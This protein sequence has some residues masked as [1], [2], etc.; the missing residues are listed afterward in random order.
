MPAGRPKAPRTLHPSA[1]WGL[2]ILVGIVAGFGAVGFRDLIGIFHNL[3]FLGKL[4]VYYDANAH[5]PR[6]PWGP[7]VILI[8]VVG[9]F[10]VVFLVKNFAPEAK[11]HGVPEV[12]D[13]VYNHKGVIRPIVSLVKALASALSIGSGASIGREGPII[14]IGSSFGSTIGQLLNLAVWQRITLIAAGAGGGIA[15][16]FNTPVGGLLF[17]VE[18]VMHEIS[19]RTLVPVVTAT[20]T[21]TYVGRVFFGDHPSFSVPRLETLYFR[22]ANPEV[23]LA[24]ILL[25][26]IT[27]LAAA[28]FIYSVYGM[29]TFFDE[30]LK[31]SYYVKHASAMLIVGLLMYGFFAGA[32]HYYVEGVGYSTIQDILTGTAFPIYFL[33]LLFAGKLL[34]TSL[35]LGSGGS[36]G[37]FSPSLFLGATIGAAYGALLHRFFPSLGVSVPAFAVVAMAGVVGG[38][39]GAAMASIVM[40]FEMTLDYT[41]ILPL[42]LTV[43]VSYAV[44]RRLVSD[45]IYTRKLD[46]RGA[47]V[48]EMLRADLLM[49]MHAAGVMNSHVKSVPAGTRL[50]DLPASGPGPFLVLD[51]SGA[52]TGAV[53]GE[54]LADLKRAPS[55]K[56][57]GDVVSS[58]HVVV[59]PSATLWEVIGAMR[60]S[61]SGIAL[62]A[63]HDG[64]LRV[65]AVHGI[66]TRKHIVDSLAGDLEMF[67]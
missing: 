23:L 15:A 24:Y 12:I 38:S 51:D 2:S 32:G 63:T 53:L 43:A 36:G 11:G 60:A 47:P 4:S 16:T 57:I 44:R 8:P 25:G 54:T 46:L 13:A 35:T 14:Q 67:R 37:V 52:V 49:S 3:L 45:S 18:I 41:V 50:E 48:P 21:A 34:A 42:T 62:V 22:A 27:G 59:P 29:E 30:R 40:I 31:A 28:V 55:A 7:F 10:G 9:A 65:D 61:G 56:I 33:V 1:L 58:D 6:S 17:A 39:T 64:H 5:T 20:A 19:V 26:A 66:I